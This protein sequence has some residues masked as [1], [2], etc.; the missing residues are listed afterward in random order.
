MRIRSLEQ[1]TKVCRAPPLLAWRATA[2]ATLSPG[3]GECERECESVC[4]S[5]RE[6][7]PLAWRA[8]AAATP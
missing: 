7:S 4:V 6:T 1:E 2:A 5:E 3:V 8:T